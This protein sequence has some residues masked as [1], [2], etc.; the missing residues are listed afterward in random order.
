MESLARHFST[1]VEIVRLPVALLRFHSHIDP[2]R[3][4]EAYRY[5]TKPHP[6]YRVIQNKSVG[7]ALIDLHATPDRDSYLEKIQGK[8]RGAYHAKR[9]RARGYVVSEIERNNFIEEIHAINISVETRQGRPMEQHYLQKVTQ[10]ENW[11]HFKYF[12]LFDASGKLMAYANLGVYGDFCAFS[13]VIGCRN[14]DGIMHL[15]VMDIVCGLIEEGAL[16]YVMYDTFFGARPG[17]R[18]F[19]LALGFQPYRAKYSLK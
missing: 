10:F 14:N 6:K 12:G 1:V 3:I 11:P 8:N 5:F 13:H 9:A 2:S 18:Q 16:N 17:L 7:A 19:K 4:H 15:L